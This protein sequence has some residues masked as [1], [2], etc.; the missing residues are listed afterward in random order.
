MRY[1]SRVETHRSAAPA[2]ALEAGLMEA[3]A[4][5][6]R[7]AWLHVHAPR[8]ADRPDGLARY[9]GLQRDD[10]RRLL[11]ATFLPETARSSHPAQAPGG[12]AGMRP[13]PIGTARLDVRFEAPLTALA[14]SLGGG[15]DVRVRGSVDL[16]QGAASGP[17]L[18]ALAMGTRVREHHVRRL[19]LAGLLSA[20]A[21]WPAS[22]L[23]V[24]HVDTSSRS[25][26][27]AE[28]WTSV[29][30]TARCLDERRRLPRRLEAVA[31][32]LSASREPTT[33][34]GPH[35]FRPRRC[36]FAGRCW[37]RLEGRSIARVWGLRNATR[38]AWRSSGWLVLEHVPDP[39]PGLTSQERLAL[40]DAREG[41]IRVDRPALGA[42]L[43]RLR[44]PIAYLDME[45]ATPA[46]PLVEG[47]APFE[48]LPFQYSVHLEG[49][50]GSVEALT[51]LRFDPPADPRPPL[52]EALTAAL[53]RASSIVV[54]DAASERRLL[55]ALAGAAPGVAASLNAAGERLW[56]LLLVIQGA[57]RH[58]GFGARWDLKQVATTLVPDSYSGV[59]IADGLAAQ[60]AWRELL[61]APRPDREE[62]LKRYC[63]ADSRAM[64]DIVRVLRSWLA[65]DG[66]VPSD[67]SLSPPRRP[68]P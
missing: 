24:L 67:G 41:R 5:C 19:A 1:A 50:D 22:K 54:Y 44:F 15:S 59:R 58:P 37:G 48:P 42:A 68:P 61:R 34:V 62:A 13:P 23:H 28:L 30:V 46:V 3:W 38:R 10:L 6:E 21:G 18:A 36:P 12:R 33:A 45:F 29:D 8:E 51:G 57:L 52:A 17:K 47:T 31:A 64:L 27:P 49:E 32:T 65:P 35:C 60:A 39:A 4:Q 55:T 9:L 63:E 53:D 25:A 11:H 16:V 20:A 43:A 56:D 66:A 14:P 2:L 26:T 7:R 40:R